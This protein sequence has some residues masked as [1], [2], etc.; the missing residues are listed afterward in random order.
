[1]TTQDYDPIVRSSAVFEV[2]VESIIEY[3][4]S[5]FHMMLWSKVDAFAICVHMTYGELHWAILVT[6]KTTP[7]VIC[8]YA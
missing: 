2:D 6:S 3:K 4:S 5:K 8:S 7:S 1:M